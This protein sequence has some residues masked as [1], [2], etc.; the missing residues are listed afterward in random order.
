MI[1][2]LVETKYQL[3]HSLSV[4]AASKIVNF[5]QCVWLLSAPYDWAAAI[6][7]DSSIS[8]ILQV[9]F[10]NSASRLILSV[11]NCSVISKSKRYAPTIKVSRV[12][13]PLLVGYWDRNEQ[14]KPGNIGP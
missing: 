9:T 6:I 13:S 12:M 5:K 2:R 14:S 7:I 8:T 1:W 3:N 11:F 4:W 10:K